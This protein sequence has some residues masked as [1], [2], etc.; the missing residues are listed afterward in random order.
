[1]CL[2]RQFLL[3]PIRRCLRAPEK[4]PTLAAGV[5]E[6]DPSPGSDLYM[7]PNPGPRGT[8]A[9]TPGR[10][11][12]HAPPRIPSHRNLQIV[13]PSVAREAL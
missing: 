5:S 4:A 13:A 8:L 2:G 12:H 1:M 10:C 9:D 6:N 3:Y 11:A 7:D